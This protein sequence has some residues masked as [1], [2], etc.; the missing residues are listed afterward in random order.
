V[1]IGVRGLRNRYRQAGLGA[2]LVASLGPPVSSAAV[3]AHSR[4]PPRLKVP[5]TAVLR[6]ERARAA[7]VEGG[8]RGTL[9]LYSEDAER[10]IEVEGRQV[11]LEF[12]SSAALAAT[13]DRAPV[14]ESEIRGFLRGD[15]LTGGGG[16]LY[17]VT[18]YRAGRVP[19]VLIH[20]T[21]SSPGRWADV[22]NELDSDPRIGPRCQFWF[23]SYNTGNPL[24]YS[25]GLLREALSQ[26]VG[27]LDPLGSDPALRRMVLVG[28]SQGGLLAKLA[29]VDS[30][31]QF[32]DNVSG[33][34]FETLKVSAGTAAIL[35]RS[36]FLEPLP[37]VTRVVFMATPQRGSDM[38][39]RLARWIPGLLRRAV[40]LPPTL[41]HATGEILTGSEDPFLRLMLQQ[42]L[43]RSVDNM[44]PGNRGLRTLASLPVVPG[45]KA[46]SI[47]AVRG[48]G[49]P[50][51]GSDGV[52]S[53]RSAHLEEA[54]SERVVRSGHSVQSHP[55]AIEE[56]RRIL[57]EHLY[58]PEA[59]ERPVRTVRN[60]RQP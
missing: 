15:F 8:V 26:T 38:A 44:S 18:P 16:G 5:V 58:G 23:F 46:H 12:E 47:I 17:T 10:T 39:G 56:I 42:G 13:L 6:L 36:L 59:A 37:F 4:V 2:P 3:P 60:G 30:G 45:V 57:L 28:H 34:P 27:E 54:V 21:A 20:G 19:V 1:K 53:Y 29:V 24:L 14:W 51:D 50:E 52:V 41:L 7:L 40:Q 55:E 22:L 9:A 11:P 48:D 25:G 32:W 31:T 33:S 43:P 49:P 35:R